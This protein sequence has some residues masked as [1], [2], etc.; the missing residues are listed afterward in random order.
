[1]AA[2]DL[3]IGAGGA[4]VWER[5]CLGL[6]SLVVSIA[7]NQEPVCKD[8]ASAGLIKYLGCQEKVDEAL[9]LSALNDI[10]DS[11]SLPDWS[12]RCHAECDGEGVQRT[13]GVIVARDLQLAS[14]R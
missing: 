2:A 7:E 5:L 11:K 8:L 6:P 13:A 12:R 9:I 3:A 4:T 1:M 10:I 14:A